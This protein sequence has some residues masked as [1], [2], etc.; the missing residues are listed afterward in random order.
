MTEVDNGQLGTIDW[1]K[2]AGDTLG[3]SSHMDMDVVVRLTA[4]PSSRVRRRTRGN[5]NDTGLREAGTSGRNRVRRK[6]GDDDGRLRRK[7]GTET[8]GLYADVTPDVKE[9]V[10]QYAKASGFPVW[11]VVEAA[12]RAGVPGPDG[13]PTNWPDPPEVKAREE[14]ESRHYDSDLPGIAA[15]IAEGRTAH[16]QASKLGKGSEAA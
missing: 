3:A 6:S 2:A 10:G 4:M 7:A 14:D 1:L 8:V 13:Y 11:A 9:L 12:I 5:H 15:E 16:D